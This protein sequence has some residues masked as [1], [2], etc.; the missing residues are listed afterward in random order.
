M[1][2][3]FLLGSPALVKK[4][5][6]PLADVSAAGYANTDSAALTGR[7]VFMNYFRHMR[8]VLWLDPSVYTEIS[9]AALRYCVVNVT[10]LGLIYGIAAVRFSGR[11]LAQTGSPVTGS[12]NPLVVMLAGASIAF[13]LHGGAA[14]FVWV[15]CRGIGGRPAFL[16]L[17]LNMG[18]AAISYWPLAPVTAAY[19]SGGTSPAGHLYAI[20]AAAYALA[21][22]FIAVKQSSGL[23]HV[24]ALLAIAACIIYIC[25]FLYLWI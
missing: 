23:S 1:L 18:I 10:V 6:Y 5:A 16:P 2:D 7:H 14:L 12:F 22:T 19:Q 9:S 3:G 17:Y 20:I 13:L 8:R 24:K 15:F 11:L 21:V 25:C 4:W